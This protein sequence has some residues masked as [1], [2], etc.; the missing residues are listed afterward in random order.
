MGLLLALCIGII[1][2]ILCK[3]TMLW[4]YEKVFCNDKMFGI[5]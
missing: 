5:I 3:G 1:V 4:Y 2:G